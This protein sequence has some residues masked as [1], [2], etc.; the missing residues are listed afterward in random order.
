MQCDLTSKQLRK[1]TNYIQQSESAIK[2]RFLNSG[3]LNLLAFELFASQQRG[4]LQE[5]GFPCL[6]LFM[7]FFIDGRVRL[8]KS[9]SVKRDQHSAS[10]QS[11]PKIKQHDHHKTHLRTTKVYIAPK[12]KF[13]SLKILLFFQLP[14]YSLVP[15]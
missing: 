4:F 7:P 8:F 2:H 11:S 13:L 3:N 14:K 10:F 9:F 12:S 1:S 5:T 6:K 15:K